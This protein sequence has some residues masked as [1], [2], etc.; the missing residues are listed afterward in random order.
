M[1]MQ[2]HQMT[3]DELLRE[4]GTDAAQGLSGYEAKARLERYGRNR[5]VEQKKESRLLKFAGHFTELIILVLIAAA[6]IAAALGE[7]V[8]SIA[9]LAIVFMNG[10]IGFVQDEKAEKV[11]EALKRLTA[12]LARVIRD[13][14]QATGDANELVPGDVVVFEAGSSVPADCRIIEAVSLRIDESAI[15]GESHAVDKDAGAIENAMPLGDRINMAYLGTTIV[16]GR[17]KAVVVATGQSSEMGRIAKLLQESKPEPTPLQKNLADFGRKLVYAAG[18]VCALIFFLGVMRGEGV[19]PMFLTAISLAVAAIPEGLPAVVTITFAL[20]VQRMVKRN[21]I[22]RKLPSVESLGAATVIASDKTGTLTQNQM[23]VKTVSLAGGRAITVTGSGYAPNGEF[24]VGHE[25]IAP[26][27]IEALALALRASVLCSSSE[28][29]KKPDN[30]WTV[31]GD[32]TEGAL[33]SVALKAGITKEGAAHGMSFI[34]ELPFDPERKMMTTVW[35]TGGGSYMAFTKGALERILPLCSSVIDDDAA[36]T[37][38]DKDTADITAANDAMS[39]QA[40]R[41]L[42]IACRESK[43][44]LDL[45]HPRSVESGLTFLALAGIIDPARPEAADAVAKALS[46]GITPVMITGDH[47]I[48]AI[49]VAREI[50]IYKDHDMALTGAELDGLDEAALSRA[51]PNVKVYARV[52]PEH[53]L[54]IVKAWKGRGAI[55]AM[56]G[57]GVN[58][59]PALKEAHIGV[60]MGITGTDVTKEASDMV[61]TD[62]NFSSIVSAVEEG[63]GVYDNIRRAVY[64]LLSTNIG[65]IL[66]FLASS[67]LGMPLPLLPVQILWT[68]LVT[69]GLPALALAME[70]IEPGAMKRPPRD[71]NEGIITQE[72]LVVLLVQ[73]AFMALCIL[74]VYAAELY[75]LDAS[76]AK[77]QTMAFTVLVFY[78]KFHVFNCRSM[79]E[80]IFKIGPFSNL[81]LNIAVAIILVSQILIVHVPS[82]AAIFKVAPLTI[83]DWVVVFAVSVQPLILMEIAKAVHRRR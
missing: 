83:T 37:I 82:L 46:A 72:L 61:L 57:D 18:L 78:R 56:T 75:W 5:L 34:G 36:R 33:L 79:K 40:M 9:I 23:T 4:L 8:D 74:G 15:T 71:K 60:A 59:A 13:G 1:A 6:I 41:V 52:N 24:L 16:Y 32:P 42:C 19:L 81:T 31:I 30:S 29:L 27:G 39:A 65:L 26:N 49:A 10:V 63:R 55:I 25:V 44:P 2:W 76:L 50:G 69:D 20:G 22:I 58:D 62:D 28:L 11:M 3:T 43:D 68:N 51:L 80:S 64:F 53:K 73:G 14:S 17:G 66:L 7:W 45:H 35:R 67:V 12:P 21:V 47:K 48:T 77:A 38:I 70:K 54:R